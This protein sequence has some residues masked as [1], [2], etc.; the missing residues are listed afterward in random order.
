M[1]DSK[2]KILNIALDSNVFRNLDFINYLTIH[3]DLISVF[4]PPI[5][6]LEVG[7]F[8][9]AKGSTW[10]DFM[11]D[12]NKFK[13]KL[14]DW[15][16]IKIKDVLDNSIKEKN[17]L[18]FKHHFRDFIIGTQCSEL[19]YPLITYNSNHFKWMKKDLIQTPETFILFFEK[20]YLS[21]LEKNNLK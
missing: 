19:S 20:N 21:K 17:K 11:K 16:S 4:L 9:L 15:N 12:I 7:Y 5:V 1:S 18:P 6:Q 3:K 8:Y 2:K 13:G 10:N 14:L